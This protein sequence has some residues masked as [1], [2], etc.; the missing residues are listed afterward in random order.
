MRFSVPAR[1]ERKINFSVNPPSDALPGGHYGAIFL[2]NPESTSADANS[3][4]MVRRAGVLLLVNVPGNLIYDTEIGE[5][6]IEVPDLNSAPEE[7]L[8]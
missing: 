3:V 6:K 2:N 7:T 1:G 4:K 5:I 8:P